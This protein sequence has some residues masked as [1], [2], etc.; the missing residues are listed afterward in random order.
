M[1]RFKRFEL[2]MIETKM[3]ISGPIPNGHGYLAAVPEVVQL[4]RMVCRDPKERR[5]Q[6]F[7]QILPGN[8]G[9]TAK[10]IK[11]T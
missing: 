6:S 7:E 2:E 10:S 5:G 3:F 8:A 1:T 4:V 11:G 9:D